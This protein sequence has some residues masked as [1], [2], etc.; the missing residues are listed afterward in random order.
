M[1]FQDI[2]TQVAAHPQEL[3]ETTKIIGGA[4][5]LIVTGSF[6]S[7]FTYWLVRGK[8]ASE[9]SKNIADAHKSEADAT[10]SNAETVKILNA[11]LD[12]VLVNARVLRK[13]VAL[14]EEANEQLT[15]Q[16]RHERRERIKDTRRTVHSVKNIVREIR[17]LVDNLIAVGIEQALRMRGVRALEASYTLEGVLRK[18]EKELVEKENP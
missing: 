5:A 3:S 13:S 11:E 9:T 16:V 14:L 17:V 7:A 1:L 2:P 8:T 4:V 12:E 18:R 10:K 6:S 15:G